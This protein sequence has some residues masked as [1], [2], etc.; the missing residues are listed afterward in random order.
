VAMLENP[1]HESAGSVF[2]GPFK[3]GLLHLTLF[4]GE[5]NA[6]TQYTRCGVVVM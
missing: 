4:N 3:V 1:W 6:L 5:L 2:A